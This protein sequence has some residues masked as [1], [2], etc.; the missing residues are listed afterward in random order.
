MGEPLQIVGRSGSL[1]TRV[2]LIFAEVLRVEYELLLVNGLAETDPTMYA[3]N[4][5]LRI[6]VLRDGD[7][8]LFGAQNICR[9]FVERAATPPIVV[10]PEDL[11]DIVSRNAQELVWNCMT[12]QVQILMAEDIGKLNSDNVILLKARAG[13]EFG[14]EWLDHHAMQVLQVLPDPRH[15]SL[16]EVTLFCLIDHLKFGQTVPVTRFSSLLSFASEFGERPCVKR[17]AYR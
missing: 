11:T 4:P 7:S 10:W 5:A 8:V 2:P 6:P 16:F 15:I 17:T 1:F 13:L 9:A 14:L 12:A 3:G